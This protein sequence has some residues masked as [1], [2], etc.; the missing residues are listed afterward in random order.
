MQLLAR[1]DFTDADGVKRNAGDKWH[2]EGPTTYKP[3]PQVD[4]SGFIQPQVIQAGQAL[5]LRATQDT[6]DKEGK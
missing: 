5:R 6:L 1:V 3:V 2:I 4:I